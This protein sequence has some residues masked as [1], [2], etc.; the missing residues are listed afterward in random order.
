MLP[1]CPPHCHLASLWVIFWG[2][3]GYSSEVIINARLIN[4]VIIN[5]W[6]MFIA[7]H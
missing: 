5:E 4:E 6:C 2:L 1:S 3:T 7:G